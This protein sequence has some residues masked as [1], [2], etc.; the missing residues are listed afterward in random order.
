MKRLFDEL[1]LRLARL[2]RRYVRLLLAAA[3]LGLL[4]LG[5]GAPSDPGWPG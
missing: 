1:Q 5:A 2:D 3:T 4:V